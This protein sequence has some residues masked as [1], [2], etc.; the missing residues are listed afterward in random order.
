MS[1]TKQSFMAGT[2]ILLAAGIT[3]RIFGFIPR[4]ALPRL[5]GA[6]G[7]GLFQLG[8]P[9]LFAVLTLITGGIPLAVAKLISE[10]E[11]D[12]DE[13]RA[14]SILKWSLAVTASLSLL[15]TALCIFFAPWITGHLLTDR[16]VT[17]TFLCMS[18]I[19]PLASI[20]A[21]LRGYFQGRQNM[22]PTAAS[23]V[24]ETLVRVVM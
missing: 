24:T 13:K 14:R 10:A 7:V 18:P 16:R 1:R 17:T 6:E 20:S 22:I 4:I 11:T 3:N 5:I 8:Y 12:G 23:Q 15:F 19:I 9:F 21:V 2:M